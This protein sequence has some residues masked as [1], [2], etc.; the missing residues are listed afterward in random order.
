[1]AFLKRWRARHTLP[2]RRDPIPQAHPRVMAE[3]ARRVSR[4]LRQRPNE[5]TTLHAHTLADIYDTLAQ[6]NDR[7]ADLE[8][9]G[10]V[11]GVAAAYER[12]LR[13]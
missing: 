8:A 6:M 3:Q 11:R 12:T 9:A 2:P 13:P 4:E 10:A 5:P 1:M 7:I